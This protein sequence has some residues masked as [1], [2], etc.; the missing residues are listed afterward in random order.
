MDGRAFKYAQLLQFCDR[1]CAL[2]YNVQMP[3]A[4]KNHN[5]QVLVEALTLESRKRRAN[6]N[7]PPGMVVY[8]KNYPSQ[9]P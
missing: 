4:N 9:Q 8:E 1:V 6:G 2:I 3:L 5:L 7:V